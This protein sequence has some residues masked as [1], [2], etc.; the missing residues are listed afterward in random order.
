MIQWIAAIYWFVIQYARTT[1]RHFDVASFIPVEEIRFF[2]DNLTVQ[3]KISV[4]D[5]LMNA[6]KP[7]PGFDMMVSVEDEMEAGDSNGIWKKEMIEGQLIANSDLAII[8]P[9]MSSDPWLDMMD[10][11]GEYPDAEDNIRNG[12]TID[13]ENSFQ[14]VASSNKEQFVIFEQETGNKVNLTK[15]EVI[16]K[17]R[18]D[19]LRNKFG[20]YLTE[21]DQD[22]E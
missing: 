15:E 16:A 10:D 1:G 17:Y 6:Y 2:I 21:G 14:S 9:N 4:E 5:R 3:T 22:I 11:M 7:K 12:W 13:M 8:R 18:E 20:F 19:R